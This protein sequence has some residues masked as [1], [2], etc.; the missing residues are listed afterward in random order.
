MKKPQKIAAEPSPAVRVVIAPIDLVNSASRPPRPG[1]RSQTKP[2]TG[3][4]GV[5]VS[6]FVL[7]TGR[8]CLP[9]S[10]REGLRCAAVDELSLTRCSN[11]TILDRCK[12]LTLGSVVLYYLLLTMPPSVTKEGGASRD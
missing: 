11:V 3:A 10:L 1:T 8:L 4:R 2:A 5:N 9:F 12:L 7:T 6:I